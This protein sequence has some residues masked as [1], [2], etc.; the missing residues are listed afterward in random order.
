MPWFTTVIKNV[1]LCKID[2]DILVFP[3]IWSCTSLN[4]DAV[5]I[6]WIVPL[7]QENTTFIYQVL[8]TKQ[9]MNI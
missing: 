8:K 3:D 7:N 2:E 6:M 9:T 5:E 1:C 4:E